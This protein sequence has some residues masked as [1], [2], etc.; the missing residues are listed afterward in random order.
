MEPESEEHP[1]SLRP[2]S[3]KNGMI[4]ALPQ[5]ILYHK[6]SSYHSSVDI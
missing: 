2:I 4:F 3:N 5:P 6:N 1:V